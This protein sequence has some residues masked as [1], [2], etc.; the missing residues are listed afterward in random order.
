MLDSSRT[1]GILRKALDSLE[2]KDRDSFLTAEG[3]NR[4]S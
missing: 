3:K 4:G 2:S 1:G